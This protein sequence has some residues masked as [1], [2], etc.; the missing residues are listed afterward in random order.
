MGL[1]KALLTDQAKKDLISS[2]QQILSLI[3]AVIA[4]WKNKNSPQELDDALNLLEQEL[5][6]LKTEYPLPNEFILPGET[7]AS[8]ALDLA[9]TVVRRAEREAVWLAQNGGN[10]SDT[11]LTYLN[12]LSSVCFSLEIAELSKA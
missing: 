11:I 9:R 7:P 2:S 8:A 3:M 4:G 6:N 1:A 10:V 12:R 5:A